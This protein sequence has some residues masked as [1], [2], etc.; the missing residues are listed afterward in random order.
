MKMS[1][2]QENLWS[3]KMRHIDDAGFYN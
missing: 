3:V 2:S 1:Y